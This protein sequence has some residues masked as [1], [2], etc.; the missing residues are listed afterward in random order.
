MTADTDQFVAGSCSWNTRK[1]GAA[2]ISWDDRTIAIDALVVGLPSGAKRFVGQ[3]PLLALSSLV[4]NL[5]EEVQS[6]Q[7][8]DEVFDV[9]SS[10]LGCPVTDRKIEKVP[11]RS[12]SML[13]GCKM[14]DW[15]TAVNDIPV[16]S[17]TELAAR[18]ADVT[19]R[20][21]LSIS[22]KRRWLNG[23]PVVR[24]TIPGGAQIPPVGGLEGASAF[25]DTNVILTLRVWDGPPVKVATGIGIDSEAARGLRALI[26][27]VA[28]QNVEW[29]LSH[30]RAAT[31]RLMASP[32][33]IRDLSILGP[34][35]LEEFGS[36][37][38]DVAIEVAQLWATQVSQNVWPLFA[39]TA[40]PV[41]G[42]L[43]Y[44]ATSEMLLI[45]NSSDVPEPSFIPFSEITDLRVV[46][47]D[48]G[49][50]M[51]SA[52]SISSSGHT[53]ILVPDVNTKTQPQFRFLIHQW[54]AHMPVPE[55]DY[56]T[57]IESLAH[58]VEA[59]SLRPAVFNALL[60]GLTTRMTGGQTKCV[61]PVQEEEYL[62]KPMPPERV[63]PQSGARGT[64]ALSGHQQKSGV[65]TARKIAQVAAGA[66]ALAHLLED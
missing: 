7:D 2:T 37:L 20:S 22:V 48:V 31:A 66:A 43:A 53:H 46:V 61:F 45:L 32:G 51:Q 56:L 54:A 39:C 27:E 30:A 28:A 25:S 5:P 24:L 55:G 10:Y 49:G 34:Q 11:P 42:L 13:M 40:H 44:G 8:R 59:G 17:D 21:A 65:P 15:I 9:I 57:V 29:P 6:N 26:R 38:E 41:T 1:G 19:D 12:L 36:P 63:S 58:R 33:R 62:R 47:V 18:L 16:E 35:G 64:N 52:I 14:G 23:E 50:A 3:I 60:S 4:G